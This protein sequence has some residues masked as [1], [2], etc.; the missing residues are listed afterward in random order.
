MPYYPPKTNIDKLPVP[1]T[2]NAYLRGDSDGKVKW[3]LP[4]FLDVIINSVNQTKLKVF[5]QVQTS[6][7][8]ST[9]NGSVTF[10]PTDNGT[11]SGNALFSSISFAAAIP[12]KGNVSSNDTHFCGGRIVAAD[13]KSISFNVTKG[14]L[15]ALAG[16]ALTAG[17]ADTACLCIVIG[18]P[19]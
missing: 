19:A 12:F 15:V 4:P 14:A 16:P 10:Y 13:R 3:D 17:D 18:I 8:P 2:D 6:V 1:T 9:T 11:A 7:R 5:M